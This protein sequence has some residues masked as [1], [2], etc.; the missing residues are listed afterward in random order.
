MKNVL[1]LLLTFSLCACSPGNSSSVSE[2]TAEPVPTSSTVS[3][4]EKEIA[5]SSLA[6]ES[7]ITPLNIDEYLFL[8]NVQYVDLRSS[9]QIVSEGFIAGFENIPFYEML[10][11]WKPMDNILFTMQKTEDPKE[12]IGS[13]GSFFPHYEESEEILSSLFSREKQIVFFSTAGVESAYMINLLIQY[14]YDPSRLYNAGSFTNSVGS[15]ISYKDSK[16]HK[17]YIEGTNIYTVQTQYSWEDLTVI[18]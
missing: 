16:T 17:Y 1:L 8:E 9:Q 13:V 3:L 14:G 6:S 10:V 18:Q 7:P 2:S 12:Y 5:D 11:S 15:N 4:P